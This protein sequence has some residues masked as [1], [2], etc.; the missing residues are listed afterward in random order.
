[1]TS[2]SEDV[3]TVAEQF[4][5]AEQQRNADIAG[6]WVFLATEV[7]FFGGLFVGFAV[8]RFQYPVAFAAAAE[9]LDLVLGSINTALLL[10]TGLLAAA[11]DAAMAQR[12]RAVVLCLLVA[13]MLLGMVFLGI[14]GHEYST[15]IDEGLAPFLGMPFRFEGPG[16]GHAAMFFNFYFALTGLHALHMTIGIGALAVLSIL[17]LRWGEAGRLERQVRITCL[18]WS[19]VDMVW[20]FV[21]PTLYLLRS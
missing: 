10:T 13:I 15:E 4:D 6:M 20:L 18:Y 16:D 8:Y 2:A 11:A 21:F 3:S 12:R 17:V 19:F 9:R 1:M 7:L 14:K 5:T